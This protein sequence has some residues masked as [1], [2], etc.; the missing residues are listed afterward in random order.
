M[1]SSSLENLMID[2]I[3]PELRM[4]NSIGFDEIFDNISSPNFEPSDN[5][6]VPTEDIRLAES[7]KKITSLKTSIC[8]KY[9]VVFIEDSPT[10]TISITDYRS[11]PKIELCVP[12][13]K[14]KAAME[15]YMTTG[16]GNSKENGILFCKENG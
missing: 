13:H 6:D 2:L 7:E 12:K 16:R 5:A 1:S 11:N 8:E 15:S 4:P 9:P 10:D 3:P 14:W